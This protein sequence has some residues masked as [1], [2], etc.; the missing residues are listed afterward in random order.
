[1]GP[2]LAKWLA[3]TRRRIP[4]N[5]YLMN[6]AW[7]GYNVRVLYGTEMTEKSN[8]YLSVSSAIIWQ[9][10]FLSSYR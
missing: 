2:K 6:P 5:G 1:M 3:A 8:L 4:T 7:Q 9:V 10:P